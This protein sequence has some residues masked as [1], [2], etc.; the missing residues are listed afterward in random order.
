MIKVSVL[1]ANGDGRRF[2]MG[3]Y[4]EKHIPMVRQ[5]LGAA[6][7]GAAVDQGLGGGEPGAPPAFL[8][9]GHLLFKPTIQVGEVEL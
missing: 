7:K 1:Y 2:D 3:C 4:L 5:K 8:A 9:I 6:V